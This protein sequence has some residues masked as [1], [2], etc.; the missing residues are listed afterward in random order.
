M[1]YTIGH[2]TRTIEEFLEMLKTYSIDTLADIRRMPRSRRHPQFN[3][4]SLAASLARSGIHYI[5]CP[6]LGGFRKAAPDSPNM[7]WRNPS[8]RGFAD[9]MLTAEFQ[10]ALQRVLEIRGTVTLMCAEALYYSC[11]RMLVS[12]GLLVRGVEV[13]HILSATKTQAHTLTPFASVEGTNIVY[14]GLF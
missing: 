9:Y 7:G 2:S 13:I 5:H 3:S 1:I 4:D 6:E 10:N 8:F 12:D 11:H 14:S